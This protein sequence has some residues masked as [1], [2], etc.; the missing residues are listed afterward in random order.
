MSGAIIGILGYYVPTINIFAFAQN[1]QVARLTSELQ[2]VQF[3]MT[4]KKADGT[5]I[6]DDT[7]YKVSDRVQYLL[8]YHGT[9]ALEPFT[10]PELLSTDANALSGQSGP[11]YYRS[12]AERVVTSRWFT[13]MPYTYYQNENGNTVTYF[14]Y[15]GTYPRSITIA[16]YKDMAFI[17]SFQDPSEINQEQAIWTTSLNATPTSAI[18]KINLQDRSLSIRWSKPQTISLDPF[19]REAISKTINANSILG[20]KEA[21]LMGLDAYLLTG[22]TYAIYL[23]NINGTIEKQWDKDVTIINNFEGILLLR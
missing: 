13:Y 8:R 5:L 12:I 2:K 20:P 9:Q 17:H 23:L 10:T 7:N 21:P 19:I 11:S 3:S 15:N 18:Y 14:S 22:D 1:D 4:T 6:T 16:G